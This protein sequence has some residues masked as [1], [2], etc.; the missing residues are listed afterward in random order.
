MNEDATQDPVNL[1]DLLD[2]LAE[3]TQP[4]PVSMTPQTGGWIVVAVIVLLAFVWLVWRGIRA[5]QARAYR[6]AAL[7]ELNRAGDDP[8]AVAA[9]LRRTALAAWP[10]RQVA[11][12]VGEDW[13]AFLDRTGGD[14]A[15]STGVGRA[16]ITAP[17]RSGEAAPIPGLQDIA[18]R[19]VRRHRVAATD[20]AR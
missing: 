14:D 6:R 15:F 3:P 13:L 1:I 16:L 10:R 8:V 19:W 18:G 20:N 11:S 7:A 5:R 9:I 2:R 4:P 17:Y 12:L